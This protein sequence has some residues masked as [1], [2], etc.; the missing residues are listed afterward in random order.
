MA[1]F[2]NDPGLWAAKGIG[3][4]AGAAVSLIYMLPK[5]RREAASRF[6]TGLSCG[7]IFGGP[8]G[9][10]IVGKLDIAGSLS[11]AEVMLTGSAAASLMAWWVMGA[12]VR[13]AERFGRRPD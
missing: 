7:L 13:V 8:A 9:L 1:D 5:G 10:W 4:A 3:A 2:G 6:F 12:A 11:G